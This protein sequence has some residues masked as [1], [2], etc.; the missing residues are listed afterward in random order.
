MYCYIVLN[1]D[2]F[3]FRRQFCDLMMFGECGCACTVKQFYFL[4]RIQ[5]NIATHIRQ[6]NFGGSLFTA[7]QQS[8]WSGNPR[9]L[10]NSYK[11]FG[12]R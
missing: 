10:R 3:F 4:R 9:Q 2:G 6:S 5:V 8:K 12:F 11:L 1:E 7:M